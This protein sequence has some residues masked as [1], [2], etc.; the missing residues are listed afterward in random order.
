MTNT[1]A[2][3]TKNYDGDKINQ[4]IFSASTDEF[5][6]SIDPQ[7]MQHIMSRL[8]DLYED[9]IVATVRE[10][11]SNAIDA[12]EHIS[13]ENRQPIDITV[14]S[15]FSREFIVTDHALGMTLDE[16]KNVYTRYGA[17]TK[18]TDFT[19][20][21]AYGL[22]SKSPLS[23]TSSF[24][25]RTA[26]DGFLTELLISIEDGHNN[27]KVIKHEET[28]EDNFM[29]VIIPTQSED[30]GRFETALRTYVVN[31]IDGIEFNGLDV[32]AEQMNFT[33]QIIDLG[34]FDYDGIPLKLQYNYTINLSD[35]SDVLS[36][37]R[38]FD[39]IYNQRDDEK[40]DVTAVLQGFEYEL[41]NDRW[42]NVGH[43]V[44]NIVP[45]LLDFS[46]S[47]DNITNTPRKQKLLAALDDYVQNNKSAIFDKFIDYVNSRDDSDVFKIELINDAHRTYWSSVAQILSKEQLIRLTTLSNGKSFMKDAEDFD[48]INLF[49]KYGESQIWPNSLLGLKY[50][51]NVHNIKKAA[52]A[53][54]D[55]AQ[56]IKDNQNEVSNFSKE[57]LT[58]EYIKETAKTS[59]VQ[60]NNA[61]N[62]DNQVLIVTD[63]Q[64]AKDVEKITS[65]RNVL[66]FRGVY[67]LHNDVDLTDETE[68]THIAMTDKPFNE[69][70]ELVNDLL[71]PLE[72]NITVMSFDD[73]QSFAKTRRADFASSKPKQAKTAKKHT[74]PSYLAYN[75]FDKI[76]DAIELVGSPCYNGGPATVANDT[77]DY[78][79]VARF[80]SHVSV[81]DFLSILKHAHELNKKGVISYL[82]NPYDIK[83]SD[84]E[85]FDDF[86]LVLLTENDSTRVRS[87]K[88]AAHLHDMYKQTQIHE[89]TLTDD[90]SDEMKVNISLYYYAVQLAKDLNV[91]EF[92]SDRIGSAL[93]FIVD[94]VHP[95]NKNNKKS[96]FVFN[97]YSRGAL[98]EN[99]TD[100]DFVLNNPVNITN[101]SFDEL[102][103]LV[104]KA[105]DFV[106][107]DG[108][109]FHTSLFIQSYL[110]YKQ[111]QEMLK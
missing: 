6:M 32:V 72:N 103:E 12:T 3:L 29:S 19:Q 86:D 37:R 104:H 83:I 27:V 88:V 47:R 57:H 91:N 99:Y 46:S 106:S 23:Y 18:R 20:I 75:Q 28:N 62:E 60:H 110:A 68:F 53:Y 41:R 9:P 43:F 100:N 92:S 13:P 7:S 76:E 22:G 8:T 93:K 31:K 97:P 107:D 51:A 79:R 48:M 73:V 108:N 49:N 24:S 64:N 95:E 90:Y 77:S 78:L 70:N 69:M 33:E 17:S 105:Y 10:I 61:L 94:M 54:F 45:G 5:E 65:L 11:V 74:E 58:T 63:I 34:I 56:Y 2:N 101:Q 84:S 82:Y 44:I 50:N 42:S 36:L 87:K 40:F 16:V 81:L 98:I 35:D 109:N 80:E 21:G 89:L 14:P 71:F 55:P 96:L 38:E 30:A 4:S 102:K 39:A 25:V 52:Q 66:T 15:T 67:E 26:K 111:V 85:W 59:L 1:N